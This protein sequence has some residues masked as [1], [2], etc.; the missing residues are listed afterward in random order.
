MNAK[1]ISDSSCDLNDDI[2]RDFDIDILDIKSIYDGIDIV[3][4]DYSMD[5]FFKAQREGHV[6]KTSQITT[7]EYL[8]KFEE[9]AKRGIDF[10]CI[11]ISGKMSGCYQN[12]KLAVSELKEKYPDIKMTV[13]DS[14]SASVGNGLV[15]YYMGLACKNNM[16]YDDLLEFSKFLT[17]NV[18]HLFTVFDL[19]YLYEGGRVSKTG[20]KVSS[21]LN[22][23][24]ILEVSEDGEIYLSE[25]VRGKNRAY[26]RMAEIA[27]KNTKEPGAD[28]VFPVY[29]DDISILDKFIE[30]IKE[31]GFKDFIPLQ[32]GNTIA[33]H[34][35]PDISGMAYLSESIPEKYK[36]YL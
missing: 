16:E 31:E 24:P 1:I 7:Y 5:E 20:A 28:T 9:Y 35:G 12:A 21:I 34:V 14:K 13:V 36:K 11:T 6:F 33:S 10:I 19:K 3:E 4:D 25:V 30:K 32:V 22:I 27:K 18:K 26:N 17:S 8:V 15:T 2:I 23:M 29:G